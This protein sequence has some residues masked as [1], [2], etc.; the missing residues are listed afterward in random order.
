MERISIAD[1]P[2]LIEVKYVIICPNIYKLISRY[3][4]TYEHQGASDNRGLGHQFLKHGPHII[5]S[6]CVV[7][8]T[9]IYTHTLYV[10][11]SIFI[12]VN[13]HMYVC[14]YVCIFVFV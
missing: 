3:T 13:I 9:F 5:M 14:M 10:Y 8:L 11:I 2:G 7:I 6:V 12:S 1:I 4:N